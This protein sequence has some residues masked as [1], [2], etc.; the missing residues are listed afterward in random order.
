MQLHHRFF[1]PNSRFVRLALAERGIE[2]EL[3]EEK[4]WERRDDF[5]RLNPEGTTPV[6]AL[7]DSLSVPGADVIAAY[8]DDTDQTP[9][10]RRLMP[11]ALT[12]RVE[13]R[14]LLRW[15][16]GKFFEEVSGPLVEEKIDKRFMAREHGGGAPNTSAMRAARTNIRY[17]LRYVGWLAARNDW[18]AGPQMSYADLAAAAHLSVVDYLGEVPWSDD[19]AAR[20]WYAR[21][22]SRPSFRALLTDRVVGMPPSGTYADL[23]F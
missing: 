7:N 22:K 1:C 15:F 6:L 14:R 2:V 5:L 20:E 18:L 19:A 11:E 9:A 4:P 21:V 8:L 23:D 13:V 3:V 12:A 10:D 16:N 17:H